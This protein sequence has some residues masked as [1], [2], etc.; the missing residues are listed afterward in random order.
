MGSQAFQT[1]LP[2]Y[3]EL[4]MKT[5]PAHLP[6]RL[7]LKALLEP[8]SMPPH[9]GCAQDWADLHQGHGQ[10]QGWW[11]FAAYNKPYFF[12]ARS[13]EDPPLQRTRLAQAGDK[14]N[15]HC[16]HKLT[17]SHHDTCEDEDRWSKSSAR[18]LQFAWRHP[19]HKAYGTHEHMDTK[20]PFASSRAQT[21]GSLVS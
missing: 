21:Q 7:N 11:G 12:L 16:G 2:L 20:C 18:L 19:K 4:S 17:Q 10:C 9:P 5:H 15:G 1:R 13:P 6:L 8:Q 14:R 3:G